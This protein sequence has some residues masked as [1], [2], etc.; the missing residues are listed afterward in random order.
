MK[1]T[2]HRLCHRP[3]G[4]AAPSFTGGELGGQV[5]IVDTL[6][7][8]PGL[9]Q[10]PAC[11]WATKG[12]QGCLVKVQ[13]ASHSAMES[14]LPFGLRLSP[15]SRAGRNET[16]IRLDEVPRSAVRLTMGAVTYTSHC[17]W[18][19][20]RRVIT[21]CCGLASL[22]P[23]QI[24]QSNMRPNFRTYRLDVLAMRS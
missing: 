21:S 15:M 20:A 14:A 1:V 5:K 3:P 8:R 11:G 19:D 9:N 13:D 16:P 6:D 23:P 7:E 22:F 12:G 17:L 2:P 4:L 18:G 10:A 24:R